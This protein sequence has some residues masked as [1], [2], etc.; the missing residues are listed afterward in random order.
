MV[1]GTTMVAG[2]PNFNQTNNQ[3]DGFNFSS[4]KV[5]EQNSVNKGGMKNERWESGRASTCFAE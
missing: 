3:E 5:I 2:T 4:K 1:E